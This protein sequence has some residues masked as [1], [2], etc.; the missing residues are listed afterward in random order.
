M[1]IIK[2]ILSQIGMILSLV[3]PPSIG[4]RVRQIL[5]A[6]YTGY[7]RRFFARLGKDSY[8]DY[9]DNVIMGSESISIGEENVFGKSVRLTAWYSD[10][11]KTG[12]NKIIIG[13][14]CN[15]GERNHITAC[16]NITIGDDVLTGPNVLIT[17][18]SH[19]GFSV[20][21]L[22]TPPICRKLV[23]KETVTIGDRVWICA[24]ACIMSGVTIGEGAII[25]A[26]AV[27]TK[28]IPAY[29]VA[30]GI[31]AKVVKAIRR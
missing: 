1:N 26:N 19:G 2:K 22:D 14:R 8:F 27:V 30:V 20:E 6:I 3:W 31:P 24:N 17:D 21:E 23:S 13:D 7:Q 16:N 29:S 18:N 25:G 4:I 11:D 9:K 5:N 12:K 28:D 10:Y 15:F